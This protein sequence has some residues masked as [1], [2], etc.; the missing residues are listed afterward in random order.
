MRP[1]A[2]AAHHLWHGP[3]VEVAE[4]L[5]RLAYRLNRGLTIGVV[6]LLDDFMIGPSSGGAPTLSSAS[7]LGSTSCGSRTLDG[8][9]GLRLDQERGLRQVG[10]G[11]RAR[12]QTFDDV[13]V[14]DP[15]RGVRF[16]APKKLVAAFTGGPCEAKIAS[17]KVG[18]DT[19]RAQYRDS[20]RLNPRAGRTHAATPRLYYA[21]L[22]ET[23]T[24][25]TP[26]D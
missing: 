12:D 3:V 13:L 23:R 2:Q 10:P 8:A 20:S 25:C 4:F 21:A 26:P 16:R 6:H 22:R 7:F 5:R 17:F 15:S 11:P 18:P 9:A 1:Y 14:S 24:K 19:L